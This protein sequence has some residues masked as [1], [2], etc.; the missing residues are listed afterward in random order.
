MNP[1]EA[2]AYV[3]GKPS[4]RG[5]IKTTPEDFIVQEILSF[6]PSGSG[7]HAFVQI[8]K[9]GE[10]TDF[11]ARQL[12]RFTDTKTRDI[13]FAGLK[14]RHGLTTQWFSVQL[15][16]QGDP[17]WSA[18]SGEQYRVLSHTRNDRKLRRGALRGNH[19]RL[20]IRDLE[21]TTDTLEPRLQAIAKTGVPNYFGP[22]RFGRD[23]RNVEEALLMLQNP[24]T[25]VSPHV[26]GILL[27][28]MRSEL[29]N[30]LLSKRVLSGLWDQGISG[31]LFMFPDSKSHF[32]A[33][34]LSDEIRERLARHE[35]H[36]SGP[37][38][39]SKP[40]T[41]KDQAAALENEIFNTWPEIHEG[42]VKS[43]LE[44][45]RRPLRL[46]PEQLSY[47]FEDSSTLL[48]EFSLPAGSYAT[49]ILRE[50]LLFASDGLPEV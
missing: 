34:P 7:E 13:G 5:S 33:D 45:L 15:P 35:I 2:L 46:V 27:S 37:L 48:L 16:G 6:E 43:D 36:P 22:Q 21:G 40:S 8:E 30:Q 42:L 24:N 10:N 19:F 38:I 49:T 12:A 23:G 50:L 3:Y 26:R 18:F 44:T 29:F 11:I 41:A 14:D 31:D 20:K 25:R 47:G 17:D 1:T 32:E 9:W 39:G 4:H 28:S